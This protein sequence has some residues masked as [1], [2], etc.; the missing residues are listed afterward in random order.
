M[1]TWSV[2]PAPEGRLVFN[3]GLTLLL[4]GQADRGYE[5]LR[6]ARDGGSV[7]VTQIDLHPKSVRTT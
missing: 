4:D 1:R 5:W 7:D 3:L 6:K 2:F